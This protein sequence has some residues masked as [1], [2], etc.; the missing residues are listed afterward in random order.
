MNKN[1]LALVAAVGGVIVG[2]VGARVLKPAP[3]PTP[4]AANVRC[5]SSDSVADAKADAIARQ[6]HAH[7]HDTYAPHP[8][9]PIGELPKPAK[10]G[11]SSGDA[12]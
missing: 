10:T 9:G 12:H 11:A 7:D 6:L 1:V 4:A 8:T 5:P 2:A 3:M